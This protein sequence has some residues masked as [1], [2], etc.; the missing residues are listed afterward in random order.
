MLSCMEGIQ[1]FVL[2]PSHEPNIS[3]QTSAQQFSC[4]LYNPPHS[5]HLSF[6]LSY[7]SVLSFIFMSLHTSLHACP[8]SNHTHRILHLPLPLVVPTTMVLLFFTLKLNFYSS[9]YVV[10]ISSIFFWNSGDSTSNTKLLWQWSYQYFLFFTP[11]PSSSPCD[12]EQAFFRHLSTLK[13]VHILTDYT[14]SYCLCIMIQTLEYSDEL[15]LATIKS[16]EYSICSKSIQQ[17]TPK[18]LFY[19]HNKS[20]SKGRITTRDKVYVAFQL[21]R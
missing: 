4:A 2:L 15:L 21:S 11:W 13:L 1:L 7:F 5:A 14:T 6:H 12:K 9:S 16:P 18:V 8:W 20:K 3:F 19:L 17:Q 10:I